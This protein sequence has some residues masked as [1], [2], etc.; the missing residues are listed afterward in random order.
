MNI[1]YWCP[2]RRHN[3]KL[4]EKKNEESNL[5][6]FSHSLSRCS[7]SPSLWSN[8]SFSYSLILFIVHLCMHH[9]WLKK[10]RWISTYLLLDFAHVMRRNRTTE[11]DIR[12]LLILL[13]IWTDDRYRY[14]GWWLLHQKRDVFRAASDQQCRRD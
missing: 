9:L 8:F 1:N 5:H 13:R 7:S 14:R 6:Y 12:Q 11:E 2:W 4:N 10:D 3:L